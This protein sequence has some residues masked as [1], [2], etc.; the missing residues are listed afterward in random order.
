MC[1]P[2]IFATSCNGCRQWPVAAIHAHRA[3]VACR[4]GDGMYVLAGI[5]NVAVLAAARTQRA[6]RGSSED[7]LAVP[8]G[9]V[10]T[11]C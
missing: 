1:M 4:V 9:R 6:W 5:E 11:A 3:H 2:D 7:L 8:A 10:S